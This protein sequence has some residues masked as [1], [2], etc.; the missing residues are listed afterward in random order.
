[1]FLPQDT[2]LFPYSTPDGSCFSPRTHTCSPT[3]PRRL[4]S[5]PPGHTPVPLQYLGWLTSRTHTCS[6]TVPRTA[7]ASPPRTHTCSPTVPRMAHSRTQI[8]HQ[9]EP[10][11]HTPIPVEY[12]SPGLL[13]YLIV[14]PHRRQELVS[15]G[16]CPMFVQGGL[17]TLQCA[18]SRGGLLC[19]KI[20]IMGCGTLRV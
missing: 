5:L 6:P 17:V 3:V 12:H 15:W 2:H 16:V 9:D 13:H 20:I 10:P 4:T 11:G 7:H 14:H 8:D 19:N 18:F 1:M